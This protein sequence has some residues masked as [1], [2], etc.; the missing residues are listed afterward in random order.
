MTFYLFGTPDCSL[1]LKSY[2]ATT[3]GGK[4]TLRIEIETSDPHEL[5]YALN[6]LASVQAGQKAPKPEPKPKARMLA[7]PAPRLALPSPEDR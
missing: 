6:E 4:S 2:S 1:R 3:K 7:L 5:A